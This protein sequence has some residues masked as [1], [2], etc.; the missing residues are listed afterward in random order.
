M[1]YLPVLMFF[2]RV[3]LLAVKQ[4]ILNSQTVL[5]MIA[6]T[7]LSGPQRVCRLGHVGSVGGIRHSTPCY[8][9]KLAWVTYSIHR[10]AL[11]WM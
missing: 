7:T 8:A 11:S 4:R 10:M 5:H 9:A 3:H 2:T 1:K 6:N